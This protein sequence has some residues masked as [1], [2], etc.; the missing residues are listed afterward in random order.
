MPSRRQPGRTGSSSSRYIAD[1]DLPRPGGG[2]TVPPIVGAGTGPRGRFGGSAVFRIS[3]V[4][5]DRDHDN[6]DHQHSGDN[7]EK[8]ER[9]GL[10][11]CRV[12][13]LG[14]GLEAA[15]DFTWFDLLIGHAGHHSE[16]RQRTAP[17]PPAATT[18]RRASNSAESATVRP[19]CDICG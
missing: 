17:D 1:R 12:G 9:E 4:E 7:T 15:G 18:P 19:A 13:T 14:K 5:K 10:A 11:R 16:T 3:A 2:Q 8:G 6:G